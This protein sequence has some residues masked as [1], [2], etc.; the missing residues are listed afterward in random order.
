MISRLFNILKYAV[1]ISMLI[2]SIN[3]CKE[4]SSQNPSEQKDVI[5][6]VSVNPESVKVNGSVD[7]LVSVENHGTVSLELDFNNNRQIGF[8]INV[9]DNSYISY[10]MIV[11]PVLSHLSIPAGENHEELIT[12]STRKGGNTYWHGIEDDSLVVGTY[13]VKAGL[14]GYSE[15]F[16]WGK[17]KF[18]VVE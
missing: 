12:F 3:S 1:P 11:L 7:I 17:A 6:R 2:F 10:P 15:I 9:S 13:E 5:T 14:I 4:D 8:T 16:T 18:Y